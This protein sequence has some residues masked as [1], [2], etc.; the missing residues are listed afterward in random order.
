MRNTPGGGGQSQSNKQIF[1]YGIGLLRNLMDTDFNRSGVKANKLDD[2]TV[3]LKYKHP[4]QE[5]NQMLILFVNARMI[6]FFLSLRIF[7]I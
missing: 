6:S 2:H 3:F 1:H 7:S 4:Q 5:F